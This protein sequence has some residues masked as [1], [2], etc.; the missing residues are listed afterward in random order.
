RIVAAAEA[1]SRRLSAARDALAPN[2][3]DADIAAGQD[4]LSINGVTVDMLQTIRAARPNRPVAVPVGVMAQLV[5][6]GV[7][8]ADAAEIVRRLILG[9][10]SDRQ[11]VAFGNDVNR[12]VASGDAPLKSL[13]VRLQPLGPVLAPVGA[14]N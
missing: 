6:S 10:A 1:V 12:D 5:A 13:Q 14:P 3:T 7:K 8:P 4:A 11:L 9:K 2:P